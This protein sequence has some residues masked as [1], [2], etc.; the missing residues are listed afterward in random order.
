MPCFLALY[1][2][3]GIEGNKDALSNLSEKTNEIIRTVEEEN[4]FYSRSFSLVLHD[5]KIYLR[6]L[7]A[8][9]ETR[10]F[11]NELAKYLSLPP[12]EFVDDLSVYEAVDEMV[13]S[14]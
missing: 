6:V 1:E 5:H 10:N 9:D 12:V 4:I 7:L 8:P 2:V 3:K 14:Q 13:K 11:G